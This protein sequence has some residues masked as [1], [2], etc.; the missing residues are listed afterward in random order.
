M[1]HDCVESNELPPNESHWIIGYQIG[2]KK[3]EGSLAI[4]KDI[5]EG[6]AKDKCLCRIIRMTMKGTRLPA[7]M[8]RH[9]Q[10]LRKQWELTWKSGMAAPND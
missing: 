5:D 3:R 10:E 7:E 2:G 8:K 1:R 4:G 6:K 9:K